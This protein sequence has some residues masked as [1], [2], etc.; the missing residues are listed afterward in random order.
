MTVWIEHD[1]SGL[2]TSVCSC[3]VRCSRTPTSR[4]LFIEY[5][6]ARQLPTSSP[7]VTGRFK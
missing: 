6:V 4:R 3:T 2:T 5:S 7:G 1:P